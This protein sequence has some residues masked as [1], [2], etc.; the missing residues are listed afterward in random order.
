M[1]GNIIIGLIRGAGMAMS[2]SDYHNDDFCI[3]FSRF[4]LLRVSF[5]K[6]FQPCKLC[7]YIP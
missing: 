6:K 2:P 4:E 3:K 7:K 1:M 5:A